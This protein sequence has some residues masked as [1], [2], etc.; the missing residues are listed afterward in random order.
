MIPA[1]LVILTRLIRLPAETLSVNLLKHAAFM[2]LF[3]FFIILRL[4]GI[5]K[6]LM[7]TLTAILN[8]LEKVWKFSVKIMAK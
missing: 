6:I 5:I 1:D 7:K 8:I 3:R 2:M 4:I